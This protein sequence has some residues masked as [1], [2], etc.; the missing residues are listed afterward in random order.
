[1]AEVIDRTDTSVRLDVFA[2]STLL[3]GSAT[4]FDDVEQNFELLSLTSRALFFEAAFDIVGKALGYSSDVDVEKLMATVSSGVLA[5]APARAREEQSRILGLLGV[6]ITPEGAFTLRIDDYVVSGFIEVELIELGS[7]FGSTRFAAGI[8]HAID[9]SKNVIAALLVI[10]LTSQP[11]GGTVS[12]SG[13]AG[14]IFVCSINAPISGD[15]DRIIDDAISDLIFDG[16][17]D[18]VPKSVWKARQLCLYRL[19]FNPGKI[20]GKYGRKTKAAE[21]AFSKAFGDVHVNWSSKVFARFVLE[22]SNSKYQREL[23]ISEPKKERSR[24]R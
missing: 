14:T 17:Q 7:A 8:T 23:S 3:T 21:R 15:M 11:L 19:G 2:R 22:N 20:D 9:V 18:Q 5:T 6:S 1:M 4:L 24:R 16:P 13:E 12:V 10:A